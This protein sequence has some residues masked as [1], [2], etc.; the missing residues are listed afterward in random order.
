LFSPPLSCY[1]TEFY[2]ASCLVT[3]SFPTHIH[4]HCTL[5]VSL[6]EGGDGDE[7]LAPF[8]VHFTPKEGT[9]ITHL[10][11]GFLGL[12]VGLDSV[13]KIKNILHQPEIEP[14]PSIL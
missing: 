9:P 13:D 11:R 6:C 7:R 5:L 4:K 14:Q 10:I 2:S 3:T 12:R 8:P 1:V